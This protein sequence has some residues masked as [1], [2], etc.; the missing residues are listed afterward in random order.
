MHSESVKEIPHGLP[1]RPQQHEYVLHARNCITPATVASS[2]VR[3][4]TTFIC[5][6]I[7]SFDL[8]FN[9]GL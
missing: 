4:N 1:V 5:A 3:K 9:P 8:I 7:M 2:S 6:N